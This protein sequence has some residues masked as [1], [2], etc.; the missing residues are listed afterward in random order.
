MDKR[1]KLTAPRSWMMPETHLDSV[2]NDRWYRIVFTLLA[3]SSKLTNSFFNSQNVQPALMPVTTGSISSPMGLGS[4]SSPVAI[5]MNGARTYLAD[6]MQFYLE[7]ALRIGGK[8]VYYLM[9]SFRDEQSD[10]RHLNQ[11]YHAEAEIEGSLEDI[12]N[13]TE[14]YML[15]LARGL[16]HECEDEIYATA[17]TISH[18]ESFIA[19]GAGFPRLTFDEAAKT[20]SSVKGA[21]R[22]CETG[23]L[24]ITSVGEAA[25]IAEYG[26]F[27]WLTHFPM[28]TVPFYQ[29]RDPNNRRNSLSADLLAG[30]GEILGLGER[31]R[32]GDD[33]IQ[34][35]RAAEVNPSGYDW[36]IQMK[37]ASPIQTAGFGLGVERFLMWLTQ[38]RDIRDWSLVPRD[39]Q[40]RGPV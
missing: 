14:Q 16:L 18:V 6:S 25:L 30:I 9:P 31:A 35:I 21:L 13:L 27:I 28:S 15:H 8:P 36:Y 33:V 7:L 3:N 2:L 39:R 26:D 10:A 29:A 4:D 37:T 23:D 34:N 20:L 24:L 32:T 1:V 40:G 17:G 22:P 11:F 5:E 12:Q 19:R 38:S